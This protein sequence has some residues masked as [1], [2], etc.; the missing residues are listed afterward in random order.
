[1]LVVVLTFS[2]KIWYKTLWFLTLSK[3]KHSGFDF[4]HLMILLKC[5]GND[6]ALGVLLSQTVVNSRGLV[7]QNFKRI[8]H[9]CSYFKDKRPHTDE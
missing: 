7:S 1:M 9:L 2:I 8:W 4:A 3:F 6:S 5:W